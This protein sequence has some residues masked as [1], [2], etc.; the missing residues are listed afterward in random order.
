MNRLPEAIKIA[1]KEAPDLALGAWQLGPFTQCGQT[2]EL[3]KVL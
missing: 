3:D 2:I 1:K